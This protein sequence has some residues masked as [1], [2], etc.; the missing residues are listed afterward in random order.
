MSVTY[1]RRAIPM[2]SRVVVE[3]MSLNR[4]QFEAHGVAVEIDV[5]LGTASIRS[6][7]QEAGSHFEYVEDFISKAKQRI[8]RRVRPFPLNGS[9]V[10]SGGY[11]M[12]VGAGG[13]ATDILS[14]TDSVRV[15]LT[16]PADNDRITASVAGVDGGEPVGQLSSHA[17]LDEAIV[18]ELLRAGVSPELKDHGLPC[19]A[20]VLDTRHAYVDFASVAAAAEAL[21]ILNRIDSS[22]RS[23]GVLK[24]VQATAVDIHSSAEATH[25][26]KVQEAIKCLIFWYHLILKLRQD[27]CFTAYLLPDSLTIL[28]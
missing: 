15:L 6:S 16:W 12:L 2:Q 20:R 7:P 21:K 4:G 24:R 13:K 28:I 8:M 19:D 17:A 14:P 22:S 10:S 18:T 11:V 27:N 26:I 23:G 5:Q 25:G 1:T 9:V 3:E